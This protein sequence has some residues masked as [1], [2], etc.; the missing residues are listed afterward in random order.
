M[1]HVSANILGIGLQPNVL[2]AHPVW[3]SNLVNAVVV[4]T[5]FS[6]LQTRSATRTA[7][8]LPTVYGRSTCT[9]PRK[10]PETYY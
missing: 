3:F 2:F 10:F 4:D 8:V 7:M 1:L 9:S 5:L 6:P